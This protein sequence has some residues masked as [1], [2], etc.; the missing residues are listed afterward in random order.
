MKSLLKLFSLPF[1]LI[2]W[3]VTSLRNVLYY[4]GIFK[5]K[6]YAFPIIC[7]GNLNVGGTGK[8]PHTEYLV[9][10]LKDHYRVAT[11]SR[12]YGRST[13]GY[14]LATEEDNAKTIGDEPFQIF[15]KFKD[16]IVCVDEKRTRGIENLLKL[17]NK[18]N[19]I[20][21][22]DAFQHRQ[23]KADLNILISEYEKPY[24]NDYIMPLGRLREA[25]I[26]AQRAD[27]IIISKCPSNLT[28]LEIRSF[29]TQLKL[30]EY[31]KAFFSYICYSDLKA[32]NDAAIQLNLNYKDLSRLDICLVTAIAKPK[33]VQN[34]IKK[35]NKQA[36]LLSYPD[37]YYFRKKDY[38][39][40]NKKFTNLTKEKVLL[41]TEKDAT[42][43]DLTKLKNI[44][45]FIIPIEIKFHP[46]PS[47]NIDEE[48]LNYVR[49]Y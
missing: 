6:R 34:H 42:K 21:M 3:V 1:A 30:K 41:L 5:S 26:G 46:S 35:Y 33:P 36:E 22:D 11:L 23:V 40:W 28:P 9:R 2:Y 19:I 49:S 24:F 20:L 4:T 37:H 8:T 10:L 39:L 44:P 16:L 12:G 18:P 45:V 7:I 31:Q 43:L 17:E 32:V 29:S 25:R 48:I 47:N 15:S 13:K 38:D 27:I 14:R